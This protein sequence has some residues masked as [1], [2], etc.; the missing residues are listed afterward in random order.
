MSLFQ[1]KDY[2]KLYL[3]YKSKYLQAKEKYS[4]NCQDHDLDPKACN[5]NPN[6]EWDFRRICLTKGKA[7]KIPDETAGLVGSY[8]STSNIRHTFLLNEINKNLEEAMKSAERGNRILTTNR[9]KKINQY[10]NEVENY[11]LEKQIED[12]EKI[13][14]IMEILDKNEEKFLIKTIED[15]LSKPNPTLYSVKSDIDKLKNINYKKSQEFEAEFNNKES[16]NTKSDKESIKKQIGRLIEKLKIS[17]KSDYKTVIPSTLS[18]LENLIKSSDITLEE[19]K[20]FEEEI[21][22]IM[23]IDED[24]VKESIRQNINEKIEQTREF[25]FKGNTEMVNNMVK[26]IMSRIRKLHIEDPEYYQKV[27][28]EIENIKQVSKEI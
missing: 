21:N 11:P 24:T 26:I 9:I 5:E 13:V 25:A 18:N 8:L 20:S 22:S 28:Q 1:E 19:R 27:I 23:L 14:N 2:K 4:K 10:S 3:K 7:V 6:C 16:N 12:T 17:K 15:K